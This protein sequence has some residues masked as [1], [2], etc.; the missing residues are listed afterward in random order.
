MQVDAVHMIAWREWQGGNQNVDGR[1]MRTS[2]NVFFVKKLGQERSRR[3]AQERGV[4][5]SLKTHLPGR[6]K[7]GELREGTRGEVPDE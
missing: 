6:E 5:V 4:V 2:L 1:L 3:N 7:H